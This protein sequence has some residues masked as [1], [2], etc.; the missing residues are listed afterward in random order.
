MMECS[1]IPQYLHTYLQLRY[2]LS[3]LSCFTVP[4]GKLFMQKL[5][6]NYPLPFFPSLFYHIKQPF[7]YF[8]TNQRNFG[9]FFGK[10]YHILRKMV[11][12]RKFSS[13][14]SRSRTLSNNDDGVFY[15]NSERL[16]TV[17]YFCLK[18]DLRYVDRVMNTSSL[19]TN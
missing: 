5:E 18:R 17:N 9:K 4:D 16:K 13:G 2:K 1:Q 11:Y 15:K 7:S 10:F 12:H 19:A 8:S 3:P 14:L 6:I